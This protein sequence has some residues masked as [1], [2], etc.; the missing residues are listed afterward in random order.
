VCSG[1]VVE[2]STGICGEGQGLAEVA[3]GSAEDD[4]RFAEW[5]E[6][7]LDHLY[8]RADKWRLSQHRCQYQS[9]SCPGLRQSRQALPSVDKYNKTEKKDV[10]LVLRDDCIHVSRNTHLANLSGNTIRLVLFE[11]SLQENDYLRRNPDT[12]EGF[13]G[14]DI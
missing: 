13:P 3:L 7:T 4:P 9:F 5:S 8:G 14:C 2:E 1:R 12:R 11:S 10:V 6:G